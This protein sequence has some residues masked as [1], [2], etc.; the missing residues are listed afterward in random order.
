MKFSSLKTGEDHSANVNYL[1]HYVF[2]FCH[3]HYLLVLSRSVKGAITVAKLG[4]RSLK[5]FA[6][7]INYYSLHIQE[8]FSHVHIALVLS[9]SIKTVP[10]LILQPKYC[11]N[12]F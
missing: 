2:Y 3:Y 7:P 6:N 4:T 1:K 5:Q 8:G 10:S 11:I 9:G 12:S